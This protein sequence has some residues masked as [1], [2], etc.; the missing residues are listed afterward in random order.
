[1]EKAQFGGGTYLPSTTVGF[2][3]VTIFNFIVT[4]TA[5]IDFKLSGSELGS[6]SSVHIVNAPD[7]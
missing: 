5:I 7:L 6:L 2:P 1:M 3:L 4:V